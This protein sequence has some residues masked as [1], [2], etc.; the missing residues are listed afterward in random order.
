MEGSMAPAADVPENGLFGNQWEERPL[1]RCWL[2]APVLGNASVGEPGI[3]GST[4][5][6]AGIGMV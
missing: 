1:V 2:D 6:E 4:L 3:G 5:I